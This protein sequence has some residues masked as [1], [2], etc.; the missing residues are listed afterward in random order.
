MPLMGKNKATH[1]A[2][3]GKNFKESDR[4]DNLDI[5]VQGRIILKWVL[6]KWH[7]RKGNRF[8]WL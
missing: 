4:L 5:L 2:L 1:G 7:G 6:K 3:V 8:T